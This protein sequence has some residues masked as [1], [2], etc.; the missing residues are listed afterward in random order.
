VKNLKR[1]IR[2]EIRQALGRLTAQD[3][4]RKSDTICR[5]LAALDEFITA[6]CVML[7]LPMGEEIR[8]GPLAAEA[9][10]A[11]KTICAPT[12]PNDKEM[13]I[14]EIKPDNSALF[15]AKMGL[16]SPVGREIPVNEIDLVIVPALAF[17]PNGARLGRGGGFYDRF[18]KRT[19]LRAKKIGAAFREQ[20][21]PILPMDI[22]DVPVE[23]VIT[24]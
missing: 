4:Q 9:W 6:K 1:K 11:G 16:R 2:S 12:S 24:D 22:Y 21:C 3:F 20:I 10:R 5:R 18:L 13:R 17:D 8:L 19:D 23:R 14:I 7:Y 15:D